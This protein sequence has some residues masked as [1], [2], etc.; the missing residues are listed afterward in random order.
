MAG[1]TNRS[2]GGGSHPVPLFTIDRKRP[3]GSRAPPAKG[4]NR[5]WSPSGR[6]EAAPGRRLVSA[7]GVRLLIA[8]LLVAGFRLLRVLR[9]LVGAVL[10]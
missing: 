5:G 6:L 1:R 10:P 2:D 8:A 4:M 3:G 7:V 9:L